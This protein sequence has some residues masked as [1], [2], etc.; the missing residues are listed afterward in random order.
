[1]VNW[2]ENSCDFN[3][4]LYVDIVEMAKKYGDS[5]SNGYPSLSGSAIMDNFKFY[6]LNIYQI[7]LENKV[8]TG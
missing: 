2:E 1:M 7:P 6:T 5:E 8:G 3:T 4:Q